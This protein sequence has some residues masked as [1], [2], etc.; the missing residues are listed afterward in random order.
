[1]SSP[2]FSTSG[3][4]RVYALP[5]LSLLL[6]PGI[7]WGVASHAVR[8]H[9]ATYAPAIATLAG[10]TPVDN[11][12]LPV[13]ASDHALPPA[14]AIC[15]GDV[16]AAAHLA[17]AIGTG[18][19]RY[20][21]F[22]WMRR[23]AAFSL[24]TA[25]VA[26]LT[27]LACVAVSIR[28]QRAL[29]LAFLIGW[30]VLKVASLCQA[31]AQGVLAVLLS[32]WLPMLFLRHVDARLVGLT[33]L[34]AV[35]AVWVL[36]R[37]IFTRVETTPTV[38]GIELSEAAAPGFWRHVRGMCAALGTDAPTHI[39]A[40]VD[41]NF[42]VSENPVRLG[43]Q[44]LVGRTLF[45]SFSLL[46][47]LE[48]READAV[49]AHEMAHFSGMDTH[50]TKKMSPLLARY[51]AYLNALY[52]TLMA[53]PIFYFMLFFW[54]LFQ[55]SLSRMSRLREL[56]ADRISVETTSAAHAARA[57]LKVVAYSSYR[58]RVEHDLFSENERQQELGIASRVSTGFA[59]YVS[60]PHL[61]R[62][63]N[64]ARFPHPF[65]SHPPLSARL[66]AI[67]TPILPSGYAPLLR[68]PVS[69]SWLDEI[70]D[71]EQLEQAM[72]DTYEQRFRAAHEES[73]AWR[74]RPSTTEQR[75]IIEKYF[76]TRTHVTKKG[77]A[78]LTIGFDRLA[79][80][81]WTAPVLFEHVKSWAVHESLGRRMLT[82]KVTTAVGKVQVNV[83]RFADAT[84]VMDSI[85]RYYARHLSMRQH[86]VASGD[87]RAR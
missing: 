41:D 77:D 10:A 83:N 75:A 39:V 18:C 86:D 13:N 66:T 8:R 34:A 22:D 6:I 15:R 67:N 57:L 53:R 60:S 1:M 43:D 52:R 45:V 81:E 65:D 69:E 76:P 20:R 2:Q 24:V 55:L 33:A 72:W 61:G 31:V 70:A 3:F 44:V 87:A 62:D 63:L 59:S 4:L 37:A 5:L 11:T 73:L 85:D 9:D 17:P 38:E 21:A 12:T 82:V 36:V 46:R 71:A 48:K 54:A 58:A 47:F 14:S 30:Q 64:G 68:Q 56:R 49:L 7:S 16:P 84:A 23:L 51:G 42:F 25:A 32:Y 27:V 28:S 80:S 29:Y 50:F 78:T 40:G 79:C 35:V 26:L 74:Y 19:T